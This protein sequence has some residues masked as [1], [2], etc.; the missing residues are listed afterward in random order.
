MDA[1]LLLWVVGGILGFWAYFF[2][3][4]RTAYHPSTRW[5]RWS[6]VFAGL[7]FLLTALETPFGARVHALIPSLRVGTALVAIALWHGWL[8][9]VRGLTRTERIVRKAHLGVALIFCLFCLAISFLPANAKFT[10]PAVEPWV[11]PLLIGIYLAAALFHIWLMT[12]RLHQRE[13]SPVD[14]AASRLLLVATIIV[15]ASVIAVAG[16]QVLRQLQPYLAALIT[17]AGYGSLC[18]GIA[19]MGYSALTCTQRRAGLDSRHDYVVSGFASLGIVAVYE[20][21]LIAFHAA[22]PGRL[23][24]DQ[25]LALGI[26]LIPVIIATHFG[27]D[28]LREMLD[29]LRFGGSARQVRSMLRVITRQ[30]GSEK[31]RDQ[32]IRDV[33]QTL[34]HALRAE[35]IAVFWFGKDEAHLLGVHGRA[36]EAPLRADDLR[37]T[38]LQSIK[39]WA[40]YE[41][42]LPL[43]IGR[44]Q[45]GAILIGGSG[46]GRWITDEQTQLEAVGLLLAAYIERAGSEP[47]T[48]PQHIHRLEQQKRDVQKLHDTLDGVQSPSVFITTLGPFKVEVDGKP[49]SYKGGRIGR[50]MLNG[51]LMYLVAN[52]DKPVRRDALIN[53]AHDH[54][55]GRRPDDD[56]P[57]GAHYISGLRKIVQRWGMANALEITDTK[58]TLKRHSSWTT[59]TDRVVALNRHAEQA[60]ANGQMRNAIELLEE[61]LA[62]FQGDY[63]QEFN[64]ADYDIFES[65]TWARRRLM[66]ERR[67]LELY[68]DI[69]NPTDADRQRMLH[70]AVGSLTRNEN[71]PDLVN[72]ARHV[73]QHCDDHRLLQRVRRTD[74][75]G[76]LE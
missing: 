70:V 68:L 6:C 34:A 56:P 75:R 25:T 49:A 32:V 15:C 62:L 11:A 63:L 12:W 59:D 22:T 67:L 17:Q 26:V 4:S 18:C 47:I 41:Y 43:C 31:P 2:L 46:C 71:D 3:G 69:R 38:R 64:A 36:P 66:I 24:T 74:N 28:H 60:I 30:I 48:I 40:G 45:R 61:A 13:T 14:R 5:L 73:A 27:L 8:V 44:R 50:H 54:R 55:R 39:R 9:G 10:V 19:L 72:L 76:N 20:S 23:A 7:H 58:V 21:V 53:I 65:H 52:A 51:M 16:A 33:L 42:L 29:W 35:R 37:T 57:D 1:P